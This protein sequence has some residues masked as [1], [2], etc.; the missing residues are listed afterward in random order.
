MHQT[1]SIGRR[2]V[3]ALSEGVFPIVV[4]LLV[5][6]ITAPHVPSASTAALMDALLTPP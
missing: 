1:Q 5:L 4:T 2:R 3:E 6:E